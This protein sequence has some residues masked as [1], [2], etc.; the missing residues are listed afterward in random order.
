MRNRAYLGLA[1]VAGVLISTVPVGAQSEQWLQYRSAREASE[2][3]GGLSML[4]LSLRNAKPAD[5]VLPE[6]MSENAVF[7]RWSTPMVEGGGLWLALDR[8][9]ESG[10]R[11]SLYIDSDADGRLDDE[12]AQTAYRIDQYSAYF[13]PVKV[14]FQ[15]ADG[16]VTYHLNLR[17]HVYDSNNRRLYASAGGW[18]EGDVTVGGTKHRCVLLDYNANG[19]FDD[20]S[21][22]PGQCD[23]IRI[24]DKNTTDASFVGK[25][26]DIDG[27]LY[28]PEI[29][30]DGAFVKL[31]KAQD[32]AYGTVKLGQKISD[33]SAG[34][35]NGLFVVKPENG[36]AKLPAGD[37]RV[38][39][40]T[41]ES[42]DDSGASWKMQAIGGSSGTAFGVK[43]AAE[44]ALEVGEPI[45]AV[46][47]VSVREGTHSFNQRLQG[48]HGERIVLTR[49]GARPQA[50]RLNIRSKDGTY[51]RTYSFSYG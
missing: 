41:V 27:T 39:E 7:A 26:L 13:G 16:P 48:R 14:I 28:Q 42:K 38:I 2:I 9:A 49:N 50:P 21:A 40:W 17:F 51:D 31:P 18:Y 19:T 25:Y 4:Q 12:T 36:S 20:R 15:I 10:L 1:V 24:N 22:D 11:S 30:R 5:L 34:G 37:Y 3:T 46:V 32:V 23:R 8:A 6:G 35:E 43:A 33:L 45:D 29:A 44:T 47:E